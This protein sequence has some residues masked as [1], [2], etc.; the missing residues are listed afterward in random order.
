MSEIV[1]VIP[2]L[3]AEPWLEDVVK[4]ASVHGYP[5]IVV[6]DG[7]TDATSR[8]ARDAGADV[9]RH[10]VNRGKGSALKT[11]FARALE[12]GA[13]AVVTLDADGQH[14]PAQVPLFVDRWRRSPVDLLIGSRRHLFPGML[15]RRRN[16]NTFSA[17]AISRAAGLPVADSQS[18]FRL[19]SERLL[20]EIELDGT[21][22]DA[23]SEVIVRAARRGFTVDFVPIDLGFVNGV[24]T[25]HYRAVA[26]T[27]RIAWRVTTTLFGQRGEWRSD[28]A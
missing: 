4:A 27:L 21:G 23:E 12:L 25:S 19:Y 9:V 11:G 1:I 8:V 2:A 6:D 22:F 26:D 14:L 17:W 3:D 24:S 28:R 20:R 16:A 18:G 5:V 15:P 10:E 13:R 7:S